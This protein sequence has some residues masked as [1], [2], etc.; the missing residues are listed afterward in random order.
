MR[1]ARKALFKKRKATGYVMKWRYGILKHTSHTRGGEYNY[2]TIGEVYYD[3][4]ITEKPM[5]TSDD[6]WT[7]YVEGEEG[8]TEQEILATPVEKLKNLDAEDR[9][10]YFRIKNQANEILHSKNVEEAK[11]QQSELEK[12][13]N[14]IAELK[15]DIAI[16]KKYQK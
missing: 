5:F 3:R 8:Q 16:L 14:E 12:Q 13:I 15:R 6:K 7:P 9:A 1:R 4:D 2:Y 10:T 11:L